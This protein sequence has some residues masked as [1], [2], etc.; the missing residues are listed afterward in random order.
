MIR[1]THGKNNTPINQIIERHWEI[2]NPRLQNGDFSEHSLVKRIKKLKEFHRNDMARGKELFYEILLQNNFEYLKKIIKC[3][4][5]ELPNIIDEISE[6]LKYCDLFYNND[7]DQ[8]F[9]IELLNEAFQYSNWR[10][11]G[12]ANT[13]F[14][15]LD[16]SVCPYCNLSHVFFDDDAEKLIVS[17]DHYYDKATYPYLSLTFSNLIPSCATCNQNYKSIFQFNIET[18]LHPYLD[19]YNA[20]CSFSFYYSEYSPNA[21]ITIDVLNDQDTR[22]PRYNLDFSLA[23]RYDLDDIKRSMKA[24]YHLSKQYDETVKHSTLVMS[25]LTSI[26]EVERQIC[27]LFN[28]PYD[29]NEI[30]QTQY[31]KLKRDVAIQTGLLTS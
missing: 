6:L 26:A 16:I 12:K 28:I 19:D 2:L 22:S 15:L 11:S 17:Y 14:E 8:D 31:G 20:N 27:D 18:H 13:L 10:S 30:L 9:T 4:A 5:A 3:Q 29:L 1:I 23:G 21:N 25:G 7:I 24:I